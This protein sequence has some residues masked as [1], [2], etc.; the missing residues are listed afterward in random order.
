MNSYVATA[1]PWNI[2]RTSMGTSRLWTPNQSYVS[3]NIK[4]AAHSR[5]MTR[6]TARTTNIRTDTPMT[7][8]TFQDSPRHRRRGP[9]ADGKTRHLHPPSGWVQWPVQIHVHV[10]VGPRR[11]HPAT[12]PRAD[13]VNQPP[14]DQRDT[15]RQ[16]QAQQQPQRGHAPTLSAPRCTLAVVADYVSAGNRPV[17]VKAR[18]GWTTGEL[19]SWWRR[20]SGWVGQV[21]WRTGAPIYS[22]AQDMLPAA[23]IADGRACSDCVVRRARYIDRWL[24]EMVAAAG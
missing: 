15:D 9:E 1:N 11:R 13:H 10:V 3:D 7:N 4:K 19:V 22:S 18:A 5:G 23:A 12:Q 6:H 17:I 8:T 20:P 16:S 2:Q 24:A 14:Y 21:N